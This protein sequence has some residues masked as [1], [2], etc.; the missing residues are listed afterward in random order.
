M[1]NLPARRQGHGLCRINRP[2]HVFT[3]DLPVLTGHSNHAAAIK[4]FDV[5]T[6]Q[7]EVDRVDLHAGHQL[8]LFDRLLDRFDGCFQIHDD[9]TPDPSRLG[10]ADADDIE[11]VVAERFTHDGA[12]VRRA[13][14]Q[15]DYVPLPT[16]QFASPPATD[17]NAYP[18]PQSPPPSLS[19]AASG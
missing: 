4:P 2:P 16:R 15:P 8:R 6:R 18:S 7:A 13:D 3:A 9:A 19:V 17:T 10:H 11:G 12:D 14:V 5:R 1:E